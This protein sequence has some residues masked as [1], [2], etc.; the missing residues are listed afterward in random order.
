MTPE[1]L[2][3]LLFPVIAVV[4][5]I[6]ATWVGRAAR[7][8]LVVFEIVLGLLCGPA[9]LGWITETD[10]V[11]TIA[12]MGLAMLFFL[13]GNEIDFQRVSGRPLK[14]AVWGWL[15]SIVLGIGAGMLLMNSI[16]PAVFIGVAL[17][18][19]ALGTI[20]PVLRDAREMRTPFG[21][22]ITAVGAVGEF[23]P[24]IAISLFLS[25]HNFGQATIYLVG[26]IVIAVLAVWL[27]GRA[28]HPVLH[29]VIEVTLHTSGQFA[30]R[31]VMVILVALVA[32]SVMLGLDMLLGAFVA[33]LFFRVLMQE[34][35]RERRDA[36]E[37][38]VEAL[39]FGFLVPVFFINT[40]VT[41]D[42]HA[43][44]DD[45]Q[46]V[47]LL[48]LFV[49]LLLVIRGVPSMLAA[50]AGST[51]RDRVATALFGA[52]G[53]PIIVAVSAIGV[54]TGEIDSGLAAA[55]V[56]AG[57]ISVLVFPLLGL[58]LRHRSSTVLPQHLS[59]PPED[60]PQTKDRDLID[61]A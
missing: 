25:G 35:P 55:L 3:L 18:S 57:L 46:A 50:P 20:L 12:D 7:I 38:K 2:T 19:T 22:A 14:R 44:I 60:D 49:V 15:I 28:R 59:Q 11:T 31:L 37:S 48:P 61:E 58:A 53:L 21:T 13:A 17:T 42:L 41:F 39:G 32:I 34:A 54:D 47:L 16:M 9:V 51:G 33:G 43:L 29:R 8:P 10:V 30:I 24:L 26:F 23:A 36:I 56:G 6:L 1:M 27:V 5:A 52:T 4:A 45:L 40:G